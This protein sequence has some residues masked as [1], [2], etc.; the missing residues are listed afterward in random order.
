MSYSCYTI[1]PAKRDMYLSGLLK[2]LTIL[3]FYVSKP[4]GESKPQKLV[5]LL[6]FQIISVEKQLKFSLK[7]YGAE[8][9][10]FV[11]FCTG[12]V[13]GSKLCAIEDFDACVLIHYGLLQADFE[14]SQC[15]VAFLPSRE[16]QDLDMDYGFAAS[17]GNWNDSLIFEKV[18]EVIEICTKIFNDNLGC[19]SY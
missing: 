15:P 18:N 3:T 11:G 5:K 6:H 1:F 17:R 7:E 2:N 19:N 9:F 12:E 8:D 13:L 14:K 10:G 4:K 16:D